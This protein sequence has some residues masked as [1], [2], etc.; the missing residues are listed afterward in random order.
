[1]EDYYMDAS[2]RFA[3]A[4]AIVDALRRGDE[5]KAV[6]LIDSADC[7]GITPLIAACSK[8]YYGCAQLL[9]AAHAAVNQAACNGATPLYVACSKG[10][11]GCVQLLLAAH[12]VVDQAD[13]IGATPLI[14][15]CVAGDGGC[16]KLLLAAHAAVD[17]AGINVNGV[18][19]LI[20]ACDAGSM[21]IVKLL[22]HAGARIDLRTYDG[23]TA[24]DLAEA[25]GHPAIA[26]FLR[27]RRRAPA[28]IAAVAP[29][30]SA[31][32]AAAERAAELA[33]AALLAEEEA[34]AAQKLQA[35]MKKA[36]KKAKAKQAGASEARAPVE[37][38]PAAASAS[39]E[40]D[41][42]VLAAAGDEDCVGPAP[43]AA[44]DEALRV[45]MAAAQY[46]DLVAA[47]E[48]VLAEARRAIREH[49]HKK[50]K[51]EGQN[52]RRK[53]AAEIE[54]AGCWMYG[55]GLMLAGPAVLL[56]AYAFGRW[57]HRGYHVDGRT[58][59]EG[60]MQ[61]ERPLTLADVGNITGRVH[62]EAPE[63]TLGGQTT[64]IV[65]MMG[66]KSHLA[67]PCGHQLACERCTANMKICPFCRTPV[68]LWVMARLV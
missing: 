54:P 23:L 15:A 56:G 29:V 42:E 47:S 1:M 61:A 34:E 52:L 7:N 10:E 37:C 65:C 30:S 13:R 14:A 9:L 6:G 43:S 2:G 16:V 58:L 48:G 20:A 32:R 55:L 46:E 26:R 60:L 68:Q 64:C 66:P 21:D 59:A 3:A 39:A 63:S 41:N 36:S 24:L 35:Q 45:A 62:D 19:P 18:T 8:G 57:R 51:Q 49:L 33:A 28:T 44:A 38:A 40:V 31:E 5:A 22:V 4:D 53:R 11:G 27:S 25:Q 50:R 17:K 12:A 67:V